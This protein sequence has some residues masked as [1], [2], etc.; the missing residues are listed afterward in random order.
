MVT[1]KKYIEKPRGIP[2]RQSSKKF[3]LAILDAKNFETVHTRQ[4]NVAI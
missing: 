2:Q 1:R 4:R 3:T